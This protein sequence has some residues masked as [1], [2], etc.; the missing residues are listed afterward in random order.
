MWLLLRDFDLIS[1]H[2]RSFDFQ[3]NHSTGWKR[4]QSLRKYF[5]LFREPFKVLLI[6]LSRV[7]TAND[8]FA[9]D[10]RLIAHIV[11]RMHVQRFTFH[12]CLLWLHEPTKRWRNK[13]CS[14]FSDVSTWNHANHQ[15]WNIKLCQHWF[16]RTTNVMA[17]FLVQKI[18]Q[19]Q[20]TKN[21][22]QDISIKTLFGENFATK[23]RK[24]P[25]DYKS[26]FAMTCN[27]LFSN[28][29]IIRKKNMN[30]KTYTDK[31]PEKNHHQSRKGV[32]KL[33]KSGVETHTSTRS[34]LFVNERKALSCDSNVKSVLIKA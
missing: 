22:L 11:G 33:T 30:E 6:R 18:E 17:R 23:K 2:C 15:L 20:F 28:N 32:V 3:V 26:P 25:P 14:D 13:I 4:Y 34:T 31:K 21:Y 24:N 27:R 16:C 7:Q 1:F 5:C 10:F 9:Q 29:R 8:M 12:S 19:F